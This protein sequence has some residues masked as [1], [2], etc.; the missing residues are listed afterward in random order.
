MKKM[1]SYA[2]RSGNVSRHYHGNGQLAEEYHYLKNNHLH[3]EDGP[4]I[5]FYNE[6]E[7]VMNKFYYLDGY[8]VTDELQLLVIQGLEMEKEMEKMKE[9]EK[10]N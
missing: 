6:Y 8:L 7:V 3:R 1:K 9:M 4:A 10:N 5:V 2:R